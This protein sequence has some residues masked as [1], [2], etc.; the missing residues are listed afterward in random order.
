MAEHKNKTEKRNAAHIDDEQG[1]E[2]AL[3]ESKIEM[4]K[5]HLKTLPLQ[6]RRRVKALENIQKA[7]GDL[8][9]LF[10]DELD[11]LERKYM[12]LFQPVYEKRMALVTGQAEATDQEAAGFV[13][14]PTAMTSDASGVPMF[15]YHA[16]NNNDAVRSL[17]GL[18]DRDKE[19][20]AALLDVRYTLMPRTHEQ[21]EGKEVI[22]H[23]FC[24]IFTFGENAFFTDR[25]L[26]KTYHLTEDESGEPLFD[27]AEATKPTWNAGKNLTVRVIKKAVP[28]PKRG[29][30]GGRGRRGGAPVFQTVE[31]PCESFFQ[32]FSPPQ[33]PAPG[34][35]MEPEEFEE[36][37]DAVQGDFE[38]G[39]EIRDTVIPKAVLW[40]NGD[41]VEE[42]DEGM[43]E[44]DEDEEDEE[45]EGEEDEDEDED[46]EDE[47][48]APSPK[49]KGGASGAQQGGQQA[50]HKFAPPPGAPA[51]G[52]PEC[53]QQ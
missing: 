43:D 31:E 46:D 19:A 7:H 22:K 6:V 3:G 20:L 52:N 8:E 38:A 35:E 42:D 5:E 44:F 41:A 47:E 9:R 13:P 34:S 2:E 33:L 17:T 10:R 25:Q 21:V 14:D 39:C 48:D 30:R 45:G 26:T 50:G 40:Y 18:N 29:G 53:K 27:H 49:K 28:Q 1:E 4:A 23:G 11:A 32:F 37:S 12:T 15:W 24:L 16:F 51:D 36:L